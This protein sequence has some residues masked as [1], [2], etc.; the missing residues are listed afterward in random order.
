MPETAPGQRRTY[1]AGDVVRTYPHDPPHHTRL[2]RYARGRL[3]V[4]VEPEER[5]PLP[6]VRAQGRDDAPADMVYA[7]RFAARE[8]WGEGDHDVVLDL[9]ESYLR[10]ADDDER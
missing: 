9:P 6:D 3:G 5:V 1:T 10:K 8:L 7:V 2:P 4:V